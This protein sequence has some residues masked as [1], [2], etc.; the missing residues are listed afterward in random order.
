M[1]KFIISAA[2]IVFFMLSAGDVFACSCAVE[3]EQSTGKKVQTAYKQATAVF[4]GEVTEI[5]PKSGDGEVTDINEPLVVKIKVHKFW[6]GEITSEVIVQTAGNSAMCG[7]NFKAGMRYTIYAY[8]TGSGL[9][10]TICSRTAASNADAKYMNKVK[11]PKEILKS[12][13]EKI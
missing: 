11:K 13:K 8:D 3:T 4:Y 10:A 9:Q 2:A 1:R 5:K 12:P 6:K 7:F